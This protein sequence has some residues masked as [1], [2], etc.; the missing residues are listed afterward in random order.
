[1]NRNE[2]DW[3]HYA[4]SAWKPIPLR[5]SG[6]ERPGGGSRLATLTFWN[7]SRSPSVGTARKVPEPSV[8]V[9][10]ER[11]TANHRRGYDGALVEILPGLDT[12]QQ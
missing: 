1:V 8:A 7:T 5:N 4:R 11:A 9:V 2:M 12:P 3:F 6:R 10:R